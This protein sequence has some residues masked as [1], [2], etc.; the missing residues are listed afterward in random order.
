VHSEARAVFS[1]GKEETIMTMRKVIMAVLFAG[2]VLGGLAACEKEG[3]A[4]KAGKAV[5]EAASDIAEGASDTVEEIEK[6]VD[7]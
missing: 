1:V 4:E 3:P 7:D 6:K 2:F 5:D